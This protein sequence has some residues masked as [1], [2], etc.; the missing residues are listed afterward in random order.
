MDKLTKWE[1][2]IL[3]IEEMLAENLLKIYVKK[4]FIR[5]RAPVKII[6]DQDPKF[7]LVFWECFT[8]RQRI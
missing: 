2:F 1:Y 7:I 8:A 5:H 4:V 6:S 3:C